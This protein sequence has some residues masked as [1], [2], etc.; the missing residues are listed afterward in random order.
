MPKKLYKELKKHI[1]KPINIFLTTKRSQLDQNYFTKI[2]LK[3]RKIFTVSHIVLWVF[4]NILGKSFE[5]LT[6]LTKSYKIHW[7]I[8]LWYKGGTY[9]E[10]SHV[11]PSQNLLW[12]VDLW[13]NEGC[14]LWGAQVQIVFCIRMRY[15]SPLTYVEW[16]VL[17]W[18]AKGAYYEKT[19]VQILQTSND[20]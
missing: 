17:Q 1:S 7:S 16:W 2:K 20:K 11:K 6:F 9:Y 13:L 8:C 12:S 4:W 18:W 3:P 14:L 15:H 10:G 19:K 5:T